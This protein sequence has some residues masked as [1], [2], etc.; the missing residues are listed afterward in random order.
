MGENNTSQFVF[1]FVF[2]DDAHFSDGTSG[3]KNTLSPKISVT[4]VCVRT[5]PRETKVVSTHEDPEDSPSRPIQRR[6][7]PAAVDNIN[8]MGK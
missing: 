8:H 7:L 6:F 2:E 5:A 1:V 3:Y 4:E